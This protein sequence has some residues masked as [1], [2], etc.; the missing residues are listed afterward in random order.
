VTELIL[1]LTD[2]VPPA[3]HSPGAQRARLPLL[4]TLLSRSDPTVLEEGWRGWLAASAAPPALAAFS[5][6]AIAGAQFRGSGVP[7]P[8]STGYW[9]ATPVHFFA[10]LDS[11]HLHPAGLLSL[12]DEEQRRLVSDFGRVFADSPWR[13]EVIG[14]RELLLSGPPLEADGAD[15]VRSLGDD[16]SAGLPRGEGAGTLRRLGSEIEMWL[17]EHPVNVARGSRHEL[18]V[19]ALWLWGG[20]PPQL[21]PIARSLAN[22]QLF[23]ADIYAQSLWQLQARKALALSEGMQAIQTEPMS[24]SCDTVVLLTNGLQELEQH[25]LPYALQALRRRRLSGLQLILGQR[26]YRLSPARQ[27]RFW[28]ARAS[29]WEVLACRS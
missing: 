21:P 6:A 15:P 4:E 20:R 29:W 3:E 11:V 12:T 27:L 17:H 26:G 24:L 25:W 5:L 13:L 19:T 1:I 23:G 14:H 18:P 16:P 7:Q 8:Q 22:P 28:R 10:G 2:F 9:L